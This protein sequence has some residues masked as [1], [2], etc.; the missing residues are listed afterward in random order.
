MANG[1][2]YLDEHLDFLREGFRLMSLS[3]LVEAFNRHF[4]LERSFN[5]VRAA[6]KNH[7]ITSGRTGRFETG[8]TPWNKGKTGYMGA[9]E[10]S[11]RRGNMPHTKRRLWSERI[12][13]D[14]YIEISV[15]ERNPHT[16]A[17]TRF[18]LKHVWLWEGEHGKVPPGHAVIFK[19]GDRMNCEIDNLLLVSRSEL[20]SMNLHGYREMPEEVKPSVLALAKIEAKAGFRI[21]RRANNAR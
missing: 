11:F 21:M 2:R 10:T 18:R 20:L 3:E 7:G 6:V 15:P 17:A 16:G 19:D 4:G 9:N 1:F 14:G 13:V 8:E 12:S 5:S